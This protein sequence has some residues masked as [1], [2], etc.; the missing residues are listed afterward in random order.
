MIKKLSEII[1]VSGFEKNIINYIFQS[2]NSN[3][4]D[5]IYVDNVGNLICYKKG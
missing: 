4:L 3:T 1:G 5:K 2:I